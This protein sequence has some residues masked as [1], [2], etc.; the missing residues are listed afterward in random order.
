MPKQNIERAIKRGT[1]EVKGERLE[2]IT[3]EAVGP[4]G[5][6]LLIEV[7][8]DNRNR[9]L[10]EIKQILKKHNAQLGSVQWMFESKD[11]PKYPL[12]LTPE[13]RDQIEKLFEDLDEQDDVQEIYSNIKEN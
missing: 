12:K 11:K 10:S 2:E 13:Q 4:H 9:T 3:Y 7:I 8:T 6:G 5:V 1:G